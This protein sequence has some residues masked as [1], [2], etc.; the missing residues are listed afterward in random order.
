MSDAEK[1]LPCPFCGGMADI[2]VCDKIILD[3][4]KKCYS[5]YCKDF[6]CTTQYEE[7][8]QEAIKDWN[9]RV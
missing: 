6:C 3:K 2:Y 4:Y 8:K 5:V 9:K 7:I 1:P